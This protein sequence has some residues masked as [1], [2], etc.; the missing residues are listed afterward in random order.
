MERSERMAAVGAGSTWKSRAGW[1]VLFA[2]P[3]AVM[4]TAAWLKP[5]PLGHST[6][7]QLGFL[8]CGF[9][10]MTGLPCPG[11]G[12]TT[13]FAHMIRGQIVGASAAN[14]FGVL[15]FLVSFT[16]IGVAAVGFVRGLPVLATLERLHFDKWAL[17]LA[18]TSMLVW[19]T[20]VLTIWLR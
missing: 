8:P 17:L 16:T 14:P 18:V 12:L 9:L 1:F 15:L 4:I 5:N 10:M 13:S 20:R 11:C 7:T 6:H 2:M 19:V 3:V